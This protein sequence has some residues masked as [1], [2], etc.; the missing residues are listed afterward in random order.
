MNSGGGYDVYSSMARLRLFLVLAYGLLAAC[1]DDEVTDPMP[2]GIP[3]AAVIVGGADQ[4]QF[5]NT[6]L[7]EYLFVRVVD[8][9]GNS[10]AVSGL[11]AEWTVLEGGGAIVPKADTT[12]R[13]G[14]VW[15]EWT[16]GGAP[17]INRVQVTVADLS[18][19]EFT[20]RSANP[21]PIVYVSGNSEDVFGVF[22]GDLIT[23][24]E[25]GSDA[26]RIAFPDGGI[27]Y[28]A[29]PAWSPDGS[30][31][32]YS[33]LQPLPAG[34]N[35]NPIPLGVFI[36][37]V[38]GVRE[39]RVPPTGGSSALGDSLVEAA[40]SPT[41]AFI[42]AH[43]LSDQR[44]YTMRASGTGIKPITPIGE[45]ARSPSW[46]PDG[47]LIAYACGAHICLIQPDGTGLRTVTRGTEPAWSPDGSQ[48]LFSRDSLFNGGIWLVNADGTGV[49]QIIEGNATAPDWSP[50]GTRFVMTLRSG[51]RSDIYIV[52][53]D[54]RN[55][56]ILTDQGS[57]DRQ[58]SWRR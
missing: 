21:G 56:V 22:P 47:T 40:W 27:N 48:I 18:A 29:N 58:A 15:A 12:T 43:S 9:D 38:P 19:L 14:L 46:S 31:V 52:D 26:I 39:R 11:R 10:V 57:H 28:P 7:L 4:L 13:Q 33:R 17:G 24:N 1:G 50:D 30:K 6:P 44:L 49:E 42:V 16:M 34:G 36:L 41:G 8:S 5:P 2:Q 53:L 32:S 55:A 45:P 23:V 54:T 37:D 25:D 3:A 51:A 20:A 35:P